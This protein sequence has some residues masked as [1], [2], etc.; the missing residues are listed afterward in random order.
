M[1]RRI[2]ILTSFLVSVASYYVLYVSFKYIFGNTTS[3]ETPR[4]SENLPPDFQYILTW[5]ETPGIKNIPHH[6][7]AHPGLYG[8]Q[9]AGCEES[10]CYLTNN[11]S[12]LGILEMLEM[13]LLFDDVPTG[14]NGT[15]KFAAIIFNQRTFF[16]SKDEPARR[17]PAQYY[18]HW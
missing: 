5:T 11:R 18:I 17:H 10:R 8:F 2:A 12:L 14:K 15:D 3:G 1:Q 13:I 4:P 16:R 6:G 7:W 9:A